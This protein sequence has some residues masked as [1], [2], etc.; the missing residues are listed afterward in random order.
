[1]SYQLAILFAESFQEGQPLKTLSLL[2]SVSMNIDAERR[3]EAKK[4][5]FKITLNFS[6]Q[7]PIC[8]NTAAAALC[9][10]SLTSKGKQ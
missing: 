2:A 6:R 5:H 10:C 3:K 8:C 7:T 4:L 1:M 9:Q